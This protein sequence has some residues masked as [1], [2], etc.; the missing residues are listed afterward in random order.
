MKLL[1]CPF[2]GGPPILRWEWSGE[3]GQR[4]AHNNEPLLPSENG[5]FLRTYVS[6][7]ECGAGGPGHDEILCE[8]KEIAEIERKGIDLWNQRDGRHYGLYIAN[9][10]QG[11]CVYPRSDAGD[12]VKP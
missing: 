8:R 6:C 10:D 5:V 2:C 3:D 1:P 11:H 7:H 12:G 4:M 9:E